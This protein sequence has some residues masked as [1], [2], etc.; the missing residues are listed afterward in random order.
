MLE[1]I[2]YL[3]V[4]A[5]AVGFAGYVAATAYGERKWQ[6]MYRDHTAERRRRRAEF[7]RRLRD[8]DFDR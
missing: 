6:R 3:A 1:L 8:G 4:L 7:V 5:A 2:A